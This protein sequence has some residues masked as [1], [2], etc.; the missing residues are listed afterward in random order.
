MII[1]LCDRKIDS[2][3]LKMFCILINVLISYFTKQGKN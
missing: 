3:I 2:T 1:V